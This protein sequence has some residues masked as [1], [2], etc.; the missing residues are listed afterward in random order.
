MTKDSTH[1]FRQLLIVIVGMMCMSAAARAA[2]APFY[3]SQDI[4]P[5]DA[6]R[7]ANH[8]STL[9]Q[10][11]NGDLLACWFGGTREG[12]PDAAVWCARKQ[13]GA[14]AWQKAYKLIDD[15][16]YAEG[17]ALLFT[18]SKK[19]VRL[20]FVRKFAERWDA[21]ENS[22][23]F[24][25][26]SKDNGKKW[27]KE[28]EITHEQG[29]MIRNNITELPDGRLLLPLYIETEPVQSLFWLSSDGF[30][31]FDERRVPV[32]KPGN[33]QPAFVVM[34]GER[35]LMYARDS[36][37]PGKI[38]TAASDDLG[39]T[40]TKPVRSKFPNPNSG[41]SAIRLKSGVIVLAYNHNPLGRSP[42]CVTISD[43]GG[44]T[45][46]PRKIIENKPMEYSYPYLF[47]TADGRVHLLYTADDRRT[48]RHA[49]FDETWL[50]KS[51]K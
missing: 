42:L 27:T 30:K 7:P 19:I 9:T 43:D 24:V 22:K 10:T 25:Q 17:N 47:Q 23:I 37:E 48:I 36:S 45:W 29:L 31:T 32:S 11:P 13:V 50:K 1:N 40:W 2:D 18:D 20:F 16:K 21:W 33:Y 51:D 8:A 34:D 15:P 46:Q 4:F 49:E 35:V 6:K 41:I 14:E 28:A 26:T 39:K 3:K 44:A 5:Y 12:M 38:W